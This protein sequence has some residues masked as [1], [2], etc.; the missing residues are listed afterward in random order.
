MKIIMFGDSSIGK[1]RKAPNKKRVFVPQKTWDLDE[2]DSAD[3][4]AAIRVEFS[5]INTQAGLSKVK[6]LQHQ[7]RDNIYC[8][9]IFAQ[10]W[11]SGSR[12]IS[13]KVFMCPLVQLAACRCQAK[14]VETSR[15]IQLLIADMHGAACHDLGK[16]RSKFLKAE[17]RKFIADAVKIAPMQTASE[18]MRNVQNSSSKAINPVLKNS[19]H[20]LIVN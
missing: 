17:Q 13:S 7:D 18:L 11:I 14:V 20:R 3:V 5:E 16:D 2:H 1:K 15:E 4:H 10:H 6:T 8:D 12:S 19:V 9:W